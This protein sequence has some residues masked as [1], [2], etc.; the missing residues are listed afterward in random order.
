MVLAS[1]RLL[2]ATATN[3][4]RAICIAA[5]WMAFRRPGELYYDYP[6]SRMLGDLLSE[7]GAARILVVANECATLTSFR[8]CS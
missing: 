1:F 6:I 8:R 3:D 2:I 7:D 5:A 4:A